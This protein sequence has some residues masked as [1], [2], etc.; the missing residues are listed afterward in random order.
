MIDQ[1]SVQFLDFSQDMI[2]TNI[3]YNKK[4]LFNQFKIMNQEFSHLKEKT[5]SRWLK[6]YA[7]TFDLVLE[8][9]KSNKNRFIK[10][11]VDA[12]GIVTASTVDN[13]NNEDD[14]FEILENDNE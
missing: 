5:F 8:Q 10:F 14:S 3:E 1:T 6:I 4:D 7:D 9:R 13:Y 11:T 12:P 2:K